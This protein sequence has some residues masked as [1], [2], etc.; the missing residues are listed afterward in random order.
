MKVAR[1]VIMNILS[2]CKQWKFFFVVSVLSFL[3]VGCGSPS[4]RDSRRPQ[5]AK[6]GG[7]PSQKQDKVSQS[8]KADP[9]KSASEQ[10]ASDLGTRL[11]DQLFVKSFVN[12]ERKVAEAEEKRKQALEQEKRKQA[13]QKQPAFPQLPRLDDKPDLTLLAYFQRVQKKQ[14]ETPDRTLLSYYKKSPKQEGS[15][16]LSM[17]SAFRRPPPEQDRVPD[18]SLLSHFKGPQQE[19][20]KP[21]LSRLSTFR[22]P[23]GPN[24]RRVRLD[25]VP[26]A[27]LMMQSPNVVNKVLG[28]PIQQ[29]T[30]DKYRSKDLIC[31]YRVSEDMETVRIVFG[32]GKAAISILITFKEPV[33]R[34][35]ALRRTGMSAL[36]HSAAVTSEGK[37]IW[38]KGLSWQ[39]GRFSLEAADQPRGS[40]WGVQAEALVQTKAKQQKRADEAWGLGSDNVSQ[41]VLLR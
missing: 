33:P 34:D 26:I 12:E 6:S 25:V 5:T 14:T 2:Y 15:D 36:K 35:E 3:L 22:T 37:L 10:S 40:Y 23:R 38:N 4:R 9:S 29:N 39:E 17:L 41:R 31:D 11:E 24:V 20:S 7:G 32:N 30:S 13:L 1:Y 21:D 28:T 19:G 27:S 16:N 8:D 18:L